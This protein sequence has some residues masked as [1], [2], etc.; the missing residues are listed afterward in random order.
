MFYPRK[1]MILLTA[2]SVVMMVMINFG[3]TYSKNPSPAS[4]ERPVKMQVFTQS[5]DIL[6][7][8]KRLETLKKR[9]IKLG[10]RKF[11]PIGI[12]KVGR[13]YLCTAVLI[14]PL[15]SK[16]YASKLPADRVRVRNSWSFVRCTPLMIHIKNDTNVQHLSPFQQTD[17]L[18]L[19][20]KLQS[21]KTGH[22]LKR[23]HLRRTM[24]VPLRVE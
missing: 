22:Q 11:I 23:P 5:Q 9:E 2:L 12:D 7:M 20:D 10:S 1:M 15:W 21:R 8:I 24:L 6:Q 17:W 16:V 18:Q 19:Q 14:N 4:F 3:S 13:H